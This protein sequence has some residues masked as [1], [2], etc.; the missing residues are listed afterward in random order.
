MHDMENQPITNIYQDIPAALTVELIQTLASAGGMRIER[1]VSRGHCSA[2]GFWYEQAE[3]EW[4]LL[5]K[6]EARLRFERDGRL[7]SL[8]EGDHIHIPAG[9]RHRVEWTRKD[10]TDTVWLAVFYTQVADD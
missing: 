7:V 5:L 2:P 3:H 9:E 6:G 8:A 10:G 4:V 1:I